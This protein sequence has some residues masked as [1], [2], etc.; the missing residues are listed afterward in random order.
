MLASQIALVRGAGDGGRD[1]RLELA[2]AMLT[3]S[4][5]EQPLGLRGSEIGAEYIL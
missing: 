3:V 4:A 2:M 5:R 1:D